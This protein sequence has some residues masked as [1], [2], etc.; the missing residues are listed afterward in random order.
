MNA[1]YM[2]LFDEDGKEILTNSGYK[3]LTLYDGNTAGMSAFRKLLYG[4]PSVV[5]SEEESSEVIGGEG[6]QFVGVTV[7]RGGDRNGALA[8][9]FRTGRTTR[10]RDYFDLQSRMNY[11]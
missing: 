6:H 4:E 9:A 2:I 5:L 11:L 10:T 3:G 7:Q 8:V 1:D